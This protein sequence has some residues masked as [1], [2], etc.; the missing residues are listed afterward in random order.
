MKKTKNILL[1]LYILFFYNYSIAVF[2]DNNNIEK[3]I[4]EELEDQIK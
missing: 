4:E 3:L 1:I 2:I